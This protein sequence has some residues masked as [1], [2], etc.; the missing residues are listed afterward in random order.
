[1]ES[2]IRDV[3]TQVYRELYERAKSMTATQ[4]VE[5]RMHGC[6]E[7]NRNETNPVVYS[8]AMLY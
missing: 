2:R 3:K 4:H 6:M 1:M 8:V 7:Y 5:Y